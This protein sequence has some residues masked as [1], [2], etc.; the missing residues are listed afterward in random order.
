[1]S[2]KK[3]ISLFCSAA[4]ISAS[5]FSPLASLTAAAEQTLVYVPGEMVEV[6]RDGDQIEYQE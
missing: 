5:A 1:M 6:G 2:A 4:V 3:I